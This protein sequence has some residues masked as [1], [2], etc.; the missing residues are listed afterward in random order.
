MEGC[1]SKF[2]YVVCNCLP[3]LFDFFPITSA[4]ELNSDEL[5]RI[6]QILQNPAEFKIPTWFLNRQKDIVDGKNSQVVSQS[7]EGKL[8]DDIERLK[9]IRAHRGIRHA[10]S[11]RVRGVSVGERVGD[12]HFSEA[13]TDGSLSLP[14]NT[15]ALL[16]DVVELLPTRRSKSISPL[17]H[18]SFFYSILV[19][20][21]IPKTTSTT[22]GMKGQDRA[23]QTMQNGICGY[24]VMD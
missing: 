1:P 2:E 12:K 6:V 9:K 3:L 17:P 13:E 15:L 24:A 21:A 16:V 14:S 4:G 11:L 19:Y 10:W 22:V 18:M 7:V 5:E 20:L 23:G 8:R